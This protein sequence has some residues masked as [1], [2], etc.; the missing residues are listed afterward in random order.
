ML[1]LQRQSKNGINIRLVCSIIFTASVSTVS[2]S[3]SSSSE[4]TGTVDKRFVIHFRDEKDARRKIDIF[5]AC[6]PTKIK[7]I[8]DFDF[9]LTKFWL[10]GKRGA[11]THKVLEDCGL[12]SPSYHSEAQSLQ[13][14][15][16]PLEILPSLS[17]E[18]RVR[19]MVQWV[20]RA[21]ELLVKSGITQSQIKTAVHRGLD[22]RAIQLRE[23][24][25]D[26][27]MH[28][29][30]CGVPVIV[31]SA[32][33]ADVLVEVLKESS[34][35]T[36]L[37][38]NTKVVSNRCEFDKDGILTGFSSPIYHV[39]NKR[40]D[41]FDDENYF[42]EYNLTYRPNMILLGDSLGDLSM[43]TGLHKE[44]DTVLKIGFLNDREERL[45]DYLQVYDIVILGDP[46]MQVLDEVHL[47]DGIVPKNELGRR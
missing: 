10:N 12:L 19:Y 16:Y 15:Y 29:S 21:H 30:E 3:L 41:S 47:F 4:S 43:A 32:G 6:G 22:G 9:T 39:F 27:L 23:G 44:G 46:G 14:V 1:L 20:T 45:K 7:V 25:V 24:V 18:A 5:R 40:G 11:S 2:T 8:T 35:I 26:W 36:K 33:I 17:Y 13:R 38:K 42:A 37:P 31:F 28:M 34:S